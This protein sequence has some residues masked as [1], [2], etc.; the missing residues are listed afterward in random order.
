[1]KA[2]SRFAYLLTAGGSLLSK[3]N[4]G[5]RLRLPNAKS[6][7]SAAPEAATDPQK[8]KLMA[9]PRKTLLGVRLMMERIGREAREHRKSDQP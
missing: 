9:H 6:A 4:L 3:E 2:K 5:R 8:A 1:M 7:Q